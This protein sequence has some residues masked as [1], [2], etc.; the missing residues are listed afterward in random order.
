MWVFL[1]FFI[2]LLNSLCFLK[3]A[4]FHTLNSLINDQ[5]KKKIRGI[6]EALW[7][8]IVNNVEYLKICTL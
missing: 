3:I 2:S 1:Y 7:A 4:D 6:S 5:Q 8:N